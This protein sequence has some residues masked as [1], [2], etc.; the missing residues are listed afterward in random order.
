MRR[1]SGFIWDLADM[2]VDI[3]ANVTKRLDPSFPIA[4]IRVAHAGLKKEP[5]HALAITRLSAYM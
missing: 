3:F 4:M 5:E 2:S 1:A